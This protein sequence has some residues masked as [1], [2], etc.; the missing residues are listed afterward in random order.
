MALTTTISSVGAAVG[1]KVAEGLSVMIS[2]NENGAAVGAVD[3]IA[4]GAAV[5][6]NTGAVVGMGVEMVVGFVG[7]ALG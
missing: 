4:V 3:G 1:G 6:S 5:I 2:I 7:D